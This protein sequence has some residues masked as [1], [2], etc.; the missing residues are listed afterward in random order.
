VRICA[1][2]NRAKARLGPRR[3]S[4]TKGTIWESVM[5]KDKRFIFVIEYIIGFSLL[6]AVMPSLVNPHTGWSEAHWWAYLLFIVTSSF[7]FLSCASAMRK[8]LAL[9]R[10]IEKLEKAVEDLKYPGNHTDTDSLKRA[11]KEQLVGSL[12]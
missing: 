6:I 11:I 7:I 4:K 2:F 5:F 12:N 8:R 3:K 1:D 10:R 9:K